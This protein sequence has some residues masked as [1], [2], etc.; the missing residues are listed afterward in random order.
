MEIENKKFYVVT[1]EKKGFVE[2]TKVDAISTLKRII[3][4]ENPE[5]PQVAEID[6][7]GEK[8]SVEG[9]PW[10]EIAMELIKEGGKK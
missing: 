6:V 1:T 10:S 9:I 3:R 2:K 8:W 4:E 7:S 5:K